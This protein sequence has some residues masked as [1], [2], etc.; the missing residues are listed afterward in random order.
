MPVKPLPV[1]GLPNQSP[2]LQAA[3]ALAA[4]AQVDEEK[5]VPKMSCSPRSST[6]SETRRAEPR[7]ASSEPVPLLG[8]QLW[9]VEGVLRKEAPL[10]SVLHCQLGAV[11]LELERLSPADTS[12]AAAET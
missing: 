1:Q 3:S 12:P 8:V 11:A 5:G 2:P 9:L 7:A 4:E 6:P 10:G